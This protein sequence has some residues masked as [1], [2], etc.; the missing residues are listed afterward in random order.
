M[1]SST[2]SKYSVVQSK[3]K[4]S[5]GSASNASVLAATRPFSRPMTLS[6]SRSII[7]YTF[8]SA[9]ATPK[10]RPRRRTVSRLECGLA[11]RA[12]TV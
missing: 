5:S 11:M 3:N 12:M 4:T 8:S 6:S 7:R 2:D 1:S 9:R 10:S